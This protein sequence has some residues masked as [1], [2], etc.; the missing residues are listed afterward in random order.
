MLRF[1]KKRQ[2]IST[3]CTYPERGIFYCGFFFIAGKRE[4]W[5]SIDIMKN[6]IIILIIILLVG[7]GLYAIL[8]GG[9]GDADV[10]PPKDTETTQT[11]DTENVDTVYE[12]ETVIGQSVEGRDIIAYHYGIGTDELL[13][14]GGIHAGYSWNTSL[15][16][17]EA[18]DYFDANESSIPS[19]VR[20]TVI[21]VL[22]PDGLYT[23]TGTEGRFSEQDIPAS[24]ELQISGR[25]NA[26]DVDLNRNFDCDWQSKGMW[27]S[28]TVSGGT[29]AFSEPES[30]AIKNYI[31]SNTPRA[32]IAWYSAVGGVFASSCHNGVLPETT[33]ITTIFSSASGYPA[34][35]S[36]DFYAITGDMV[37]WLAR[38][39]IPAI[40]VLLTTHNDVEWNKNKAGIEALLSHYA[41]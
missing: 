19:N 33:N 20:I 38:K 28:T 5:Y 6:K 31:E 12:R 3:S 30:I 8:A 11:G 13:F 23:V 26:N 10:T 29:S 27:Q 35:E 18:M 22:N 2:K 21:P 17:Y 39:N 1:G 36:F 15:V 25:F 7:F 40:S 4:I 9:G 24:L 41:L 14:V 37:N 32:V 16:S 34:Y